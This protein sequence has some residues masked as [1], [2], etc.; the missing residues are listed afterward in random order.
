MGMEELKFEHTYD[1]VWI[2]WVIG[3]LI[4]EDLISFLKKCK[5]NL[6]PGVS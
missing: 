3:H 5:D 1:L 6:N 2:Q 4:D